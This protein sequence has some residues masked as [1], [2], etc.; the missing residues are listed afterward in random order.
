M[1]KILL[2]VSLLLTAL[3]GFLGFMTK[4][5]VAALQGDLKSAKASATAANSAMTK[6]Q[7][8]LKKSQDELTATAATLADRD[9]EVARQR[10][11]LETAT[12]KLKE[13]MAAVDE[14]TAQLAK[15]TEE[16]TKANPSTPGM[17]PEE[18][19][20]RMTQMTADLQ[21]A[22]AEAAEA[23]QVMDT[24]NARV[25]E[26]EDQRAVA[27]RKVKE[28]QGPITQAGLTGKVLAY[29]PGWNFVVLSIGDQ[30]G[31]KA[32]TQMLVV[33]GGQAIA[34]VKV[35][36]VEPRSAI[37]DVIPGTIQRGTT[38]QPGDTVVYESRR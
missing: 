22:Q 6:A 26:A 5:K 27:E 12:T 24:L 31:V 13:A 33:R 16:M 23:R 8:E 29:N 34:K 37:A 10:G 21:K 18:V 14:K 15:V 19:A 7:G 30:A 20:A 9:K 36:S 3:T 28:Y 2:G 38:V 35:T 25:K 11:E 1:A 32:N 4:G 17:T